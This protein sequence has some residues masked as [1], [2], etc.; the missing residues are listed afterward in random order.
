M[1]GEAFTAQL[2]YSDDSDKS[3]KAKLFGISA[4]KYNRYYRSNKIYLPKDLCQSI[5]DL[6]SR[7][8]D[9]LSKFNFS[10]LRAEKSDQTFDLWEK[11]ADTMQ[12]EVPKLQE[13]IEEEF[14]KLLGVTKQ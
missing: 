13:Q 12:K 5:E 8:I 11:A 14:R 10:R 9:P 4:I 2:E 3:E 7:T 6:W 1:D